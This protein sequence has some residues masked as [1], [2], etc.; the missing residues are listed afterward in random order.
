MGPLLK[1]SHAGLGAVVES[2]QTVAALWGQSQARQVLTHHLPLYL[3]RL[4]AGLEQLQ[5]ELERECESEG[6]TPETPQPAWP[7]GPAAFTFSQLPPSWEVS[8]LTSL[9]PTAFVLWGLLLYFLSSPH[10]VSF[11]QRAL[12][13]RPSAGSFQSPFLVCDQH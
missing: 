1:L 2:G 9:M 3:E 10:L 7:H 5:N 6:P 4:Q 12:F 8:K 11:G 13:L